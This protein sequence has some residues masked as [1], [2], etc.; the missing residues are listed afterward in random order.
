MPII[1]YYG[2]GSP[3]SWKIWLML[4]HKHLSYD[5]RLMSLQSGE[6]KK[7]EYLAINPRGKVP[8][9]IDDGFVIWESTAIAE[10]LEDRYPDHPLLPTS[11]NERGISRRVATEANQ[12]LYPVQRR[13]FEHTLFRTNSLGDPNVI[14]SALVELQ[15]ELVYYEDSLQGDYFAGH[16]SIADFTLYPM[17]A[18]VR[19]LHEKQPQHGAGAY[20]GPRLA[21]FMQRIERLPYFA[22]TIPPHWKG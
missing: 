11:V 7:P 19:R 16:L 1:F 13:L 21:A 20:I 15:R 18:L 5:F 14:A 12:Y 22:K 4:E 10:Y 3:F 17:L 9:L 6:L 2:S 8:A